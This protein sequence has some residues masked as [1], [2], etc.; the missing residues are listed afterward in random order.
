MD[1][2]KFGFYYGI[3]L[4]VVGLGVFYRIPEVMVQIEDIEFFR[5]KLLA[6]KVCFY[7]LGILLI[8]AGG[9]RIHRNFKSGNSKQD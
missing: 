3:L 7:I 8:W 1:K 9:I 6:V 4:V 2:K 5:Q